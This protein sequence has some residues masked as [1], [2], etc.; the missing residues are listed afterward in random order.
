M[1]QQIKEL[2]ELGM[3]KYA[4]D[5]DKAKEFTQGFLKQAAMPNVGF[6]TSIVS[7]AGAAIGS[8]IAGLALGMGIYGMSAAMQDVGNRALRSKY[9]DALARVKATNIVV[10]DAD[11]AKVNSYAETIFKFAPHVAADANLLGSVLA[12]AVHGE[13][14]DTMTIRTLTDLDGKI[15]ENRKD[16]MFSPKAFK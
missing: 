7:G 5:V 4:G 16:Y 6:G 8:G 1:K 13:G 12:G 11:A 14:L 15:R 10:K 2:F 9:M 3:E